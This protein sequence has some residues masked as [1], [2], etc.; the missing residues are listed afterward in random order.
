M[1][2]PRKTRSLMSAKSPYCAA[3][4][5]GVFPHLSLA[6]GSTFEANAAIVACSRRHKA[7]QNTCTRS[8]AIAALPSSTLAECDELEATLEALARAGPHPDL[9]EAR[10]D[11]ELH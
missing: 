10:L 7:R 8:T 2:P 3:E 11:D 5:S 4:R 9:D 1:V 6:L